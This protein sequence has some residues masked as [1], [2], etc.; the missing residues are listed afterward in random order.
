MI[1]NYSIYSF[2]FIFV[3]VLSSGCSHSN[4]KTATISVNS[5]S[6][7]VKTFEELNLGILFD[8]DFTLPNADENWVNLW[9]ERYNNGEKD[10][11]PLTQLSYGNSPNKVEKGSMGFGMI[12]PNTDA[13]L[14]FLY[15]PDVRTQP[16]IIEK[17]SNTNR[18]STWDYAIGEEEVELEMGE[19]KILA[20]Y[21]ETESDSL[22][23]VDLQDEETVK[24]II[25]QD[26]TVLVLKVKIDE[27]NVNKN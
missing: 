26:D 9:V 14:V 3:L 19:T 18:L 2:I 22:L 17:E 10:I 15:G 11:K 6:K 7:Y 24:E 12:N 27:K 4:D 8:F 5:D 1:K 23:T 21:R 25:E 20:V 13:P 16:Q